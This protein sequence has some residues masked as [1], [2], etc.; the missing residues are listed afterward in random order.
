MFEKGPHSK[1]LCKA[2]S[3]K[4][5]VG[6]SKR[7][8]RSYNLDRERRWKWVKLRIKGEGKARTS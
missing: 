2:A 7:N 1:S 8:E 3:R 5:D 6:V 4:G